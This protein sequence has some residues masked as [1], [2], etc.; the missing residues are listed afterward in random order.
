MNIERLKRLPSYRELQTKKKAEELAQRNRM[1][2]DL[3][4][5]IAT[6][7][8]SGFEIDE[9]QETANPAV[10]TKAPKFKKGDRVRVIYD[11]G[12]AEIGVIESASNIF[13][14]AWVCCVCIGGKD[15]FEVFGPDQLE[16]LPAV[17]TKAPK[18]EAAPAF[19]E[20]D[21]IVC[22]NTTG[23]SDLIDGQV[24]TVVNHLTESFI[25]ITDGTYGYTVSTNRFKLVGEPAAPTEAPKPR[26]VTPDALRIALRALCDAKGG[27][28]CREVLSRFGVMCLSKLRKAD[29]PAALVALNAELDTL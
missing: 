1:K 23:R 18:L 20:G 16:L 21:Y 15:R 8:G 4:P 13:I 17:P 14:G 12:H 5:H 9:E 3:P 25:Q 26:E 6:F 28:I 22:I 2:R 11:D 27:T 7:N 24:Y 19:K 29:Y 10:P